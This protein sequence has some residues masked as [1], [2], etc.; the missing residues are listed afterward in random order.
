MNYSM[1]HPLI[2]LNSTMGTLIKG[3]QKIVAPANHGHQWQP[4][5]TGHTPETLF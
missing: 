2:M 1:W 5:R 3:L 4:I